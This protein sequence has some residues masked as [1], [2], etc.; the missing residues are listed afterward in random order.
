MSPLP[1]GRGCDEALEFLKDVMENGPLDEAPSTDVQPDETVLGVLEDVRL[2]RVFCEMHRLVK[3]QKVALAEAVSL[4][5]A[6]VDYNQPVL[7]HDQCA[8]RVR[9]LA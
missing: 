2:R 4:K 3:K 5:T 6:G 7:E 8:S 9:L 1:A